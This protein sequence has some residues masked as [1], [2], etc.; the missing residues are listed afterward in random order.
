MGHWFNDDTFKNGLEYHYG[1]LIDGFGGLSDLDG[2]WEDYGTLL[3][4][5]QDEFAPSPIDRAASGFAD[6]GYLFYP[7]A[8]VGSD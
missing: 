7:S 8:C 1:S 3:Q 5:D 4:F 2:S 6:R